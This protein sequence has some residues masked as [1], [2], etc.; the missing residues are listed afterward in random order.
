MY[1]SPPTTYIQDTGTEKGRG[2]FAARNYAVD[3][4]IEVCP[5]VVFHMPFSSLPNEIKTLV[6]NWAVLAQVPNSHALA[7]GYGS[8]YNHDNPSNLRYEA[9]NQHNLI[10]FI[11]V[12]SID[13]GEELTINYNAQG[14]GAE[15]DNDNWFE[16]M[17]IKPIFT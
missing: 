9:N 6:F 4:I 2:V 16:R 17:K 5:V 13:N 14:G 8:M 12:R 11:S 3:E 7:L 1:L 10:R 15:W